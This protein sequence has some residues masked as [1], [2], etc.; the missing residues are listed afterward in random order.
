[1][2]SKSKKYVLAILMAASILATVSSAFLAVTTGPNLGAVLH[3]TQPGDLAKLSGYVLTA[4][5]SGSSTLIESGPGGS[6]FLTNEHVC[7]SATKKGSFIRL[8]GQRLVVTAIKPSKH[9]DLCLMHVRENLGPHAEVAKR[10]PQVGDQIM[11]GGYPLNLPIVIQKGYTSSTIKVGKRAE[12]M[13][14]TSVIVQGGY[15]GT[16]VF[17]AEGKL[18]GVIAAYV[19]DK[20]KT[21]SM[22]FGLAVPL[23]IVQI[24]LNEEAPRSSWTK[25]PDATRSK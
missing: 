16:G 19:P 10:Q 25:V 18:V 17:D 5:A 24:F 20:P 1:V 12:W 7:K 6:N 11:V 8:N 13:M 22:G 15:S 9:V 21:D 2:F 3:P 23:R 14:L 4:E